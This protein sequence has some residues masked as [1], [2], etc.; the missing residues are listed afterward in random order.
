MG[1]AMGQA[2]DFLGQPDS[3]MFEV[4]AGTKV[5]SMLSVSSF[6]KKMLFNL[7]GGMGSAMGQAKMSG[8]AIEFMKLFTGAEVKSAAGWH[9]GN[10]KGVL[11]MLP[12]PPDA[13]ST[14]GL[15]GM[16]SAFA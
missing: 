12:I 2:E 6:G 14:S 10:L 8:M 13:Y 15:R 9:K 5:K 7:I 1:S 11:A 3:P 16:L 4:F